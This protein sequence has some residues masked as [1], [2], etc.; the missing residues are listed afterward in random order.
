MGINKLICLWHGPPCPF[1]C[2]EHFADWTCGLLAGIII[3]FGPMVGLNQLL[4]IKH[5]SV[6]L[7]PRCVTGTP[8]LFSISDYN[9]LSEFGARVKLW[10]ECKEHVTAGSWVPVDDCHSTPFCSNLLVTNT[11]DVCPVQYA[12]EDVGGIEHPSLLCGFEKAV[13]SGCFCISDGLPDCS[14]GV[15][16]EAPFSN[17]WAL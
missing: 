17:G 4:W 7:Q 3:R 14:D 6:S 11:S 13:Q 15:V 2:P 9:L 1:Q 10:L 12:L 16:F 8:P 5:S